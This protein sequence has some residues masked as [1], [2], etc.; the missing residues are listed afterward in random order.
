MSFVRWSL[1]TNRFAGDAVECFL[2]FNFELQRQF[3]LAQISYHSIAEQSFSVYRLFCGYISYMTPRVPFAPLRF[4][5]FRLLSFIP[6]SISHLNFEQLRTIIEVFH[7]DDDDGTVFRCSIFG[8]KF[9][10]NQAERPRRDVYN[11]EWPTRKHIGHTLI[12]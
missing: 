7:P 12:S 4:S 11:R 3:Q 2:S 6:F 1:V 5:F 10:P 8:A 9:Q